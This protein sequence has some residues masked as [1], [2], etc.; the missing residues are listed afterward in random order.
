MKALLIPVKESA[1]AKQRLAPHF[2][3][4]ARS[5]LAS[6]FWQDFFDVIA[7]A[8]GFEAVF[9]VSS[10]AAALQ[11]AREFGWQTIVETEQLSESASVDFASAR[12]E[13]IG[14]RSVLRIPVDLPLIHAADVESIFAGMPAT[15]GAAIIPSA[16]GDGTNAL[17]RTPPTIFRSHFG[18]DSF[19]KHC[20]AAHEASCE[21]VKL[22]NPRIEVD[23][24]TIEDLRALNPAKVSGRRTLRWLE[25]Y[26][27][28]SSA[29]VHRAVAASSNPG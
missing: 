20:T 12:C 16:D 18:P 7:Q 19:G 5:E 25:R 15:P 3:A 22:R 28:H 6:A 14:F 4:A 24:D 29:N 9:V 10:H 17:L 21:I 23:V 27:S 2:S 13:E 11:R 8:R 26:S 1:N